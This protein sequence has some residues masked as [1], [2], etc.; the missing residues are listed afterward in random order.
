[1]TFSIIFIDVVVVIKEISLL[2]ESLEETHASTKD[3]YGLKMLVAYCNPWRN[4][5]R[6]LV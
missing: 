5:I 4:L 1:L 3:E 2:L 6:C